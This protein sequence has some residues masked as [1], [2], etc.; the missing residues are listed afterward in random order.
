MTEVQGWVLIGLLALLLAFFMGAGAM[1]EEQGWVLIG[2]LALFVFV[3]LYRSSTDVVRKRI[4]RICF[5]APVI[6]AVPVSAVVFADLL[7][8]NMYLWLGLSWL[9]PNGSIQLLYRWSNWVF[10]VLVAAYLLVVWA[11]WRWTPIFN[12]LKNRP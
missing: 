8:N 1:T 6:A 10:Y 4:K 7:V 12:F 5:I 2:L 11:L 9:I 3:Y